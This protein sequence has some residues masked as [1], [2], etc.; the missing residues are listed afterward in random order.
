LPRTTRSASASIRPES[1]SLRRPAT[2][3]AAARRSRH[4]GPALLGSR[5]LPIRDGLRGAFRP[6]GHAP[7]FR[8]IGRMAHPDRRGSGLWVRKRFEFVPPRATAA[9]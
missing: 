1:P 9:N 8:P 4:L 7:Y 3:A 5:G 6:P 2:V